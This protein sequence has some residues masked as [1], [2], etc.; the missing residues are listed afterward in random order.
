MHVR[1]APTALS[2]QDGRCNQGRA[3]G[4]AEGAAHT[5]WSMTT[6]LPGLTLDGIAR[7]SNLPAR[8][9][10]GAGQT[11][12]EPCNLHPREEGGATALLPRPECLPR[13]ARVEVALVDF[14]AQQRRVR[15][16]I[17][18]KALRCGLSPHGTRQR[19]EGGRREGRTA[20]SVEY[21]RH[22]EKA[23]AAQSLLRLSVNVCGATLRVVN[24][25]ARVY[26]LGN[27]FWMQRSVSPYRARWRRFACRPRRARRKAPHS[28]RSDPPPW[29]WQP[30]LRIA[31]A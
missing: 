24:L 30:C 12:Q 7:R 23:G 5:K 28:G 1:P 2:T 22:V 16:L 15:E 11:E 4:V 20:R 27:D 26:V 14:G 17:C 13:A 21:K 31:A 25:A 9:L 8:C 18:I 19:G 29:R 10:D 6:E 3:A